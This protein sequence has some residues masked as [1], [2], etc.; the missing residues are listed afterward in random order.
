MLTDCTVTDL[1]KLLAEE[2]IKVIK[3]CEQRV[4]I[5]K[6]NILNRKIH[7]QGVDSLKNWVYAES[8]IYLDNLSEDFVNDLFNNNIPIGTLWLKYRMETFKSL[9]SKDFEVVSKEDTVGFPE[10]TQ[11]LSRK[12][13]VFNNEKLIMEINEKFPIKHYLELF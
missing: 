7:L 8:I 1:V 11:L 6:Q 4:V 3:L 13:Q 5:E 2:D 10:G 12:Y 9:I